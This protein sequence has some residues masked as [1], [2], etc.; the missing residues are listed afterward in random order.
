MP[1]YR[2]VGT[3]S[4]SR[5]RRSPSRSCCSTAESTTHRTDGGQLTRRGDDEDDED[6]A[7][8]ERVAHPKS[9]NAARLSGSPRISYAADIS[10]GQCP[11]KAASKLCTATG[12]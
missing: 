8:A 2:T 10:E 7:A 1:G 9:S 6:E 3:P 11:P 5:T 12:G 4:A